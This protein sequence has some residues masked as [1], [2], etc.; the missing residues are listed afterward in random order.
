MN[1]LP[2]T[3][4]KIQTHGNLTLVRVLVSDITFT[5]IVIETPESASYLK[6]GAEI[7]VMFKETEVII[8]KNAHEI[9]LQNRIP[10][11]IMEITEGQLLSQITLQYQSH[12]ISSIITSNAVK[13]LQLTPG[14]EVIAMIKT[15]EIMLSE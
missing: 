3:I 7:T 14:K 13:Q 1:T 10:A 2:G 15:N 4:K 6:I 12:F 11:K 8:S 5:S 9:S